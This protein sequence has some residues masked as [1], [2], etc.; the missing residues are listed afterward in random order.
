MIVQHLK[1]FATTE[2]QTSGSHSDLLA[3]VIEPLEGAII[4]EVRAITL[5]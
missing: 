5:A 4:Q 1:D 2:L 3:K